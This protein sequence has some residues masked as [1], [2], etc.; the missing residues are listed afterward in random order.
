MPALGDSTARL[1]T[2]GA[3]PFTLETKP[4]GHGDVHHLLLREGIADELKRRGFEWLFFFQDTNAL[5]SASPPPSACRGRPR[6]LTVPSLFS[7]PLLPFEFPRD[8]RLYL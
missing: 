8:I 1:V 5:V 6:R 3:D 2:T 4:H 7:L